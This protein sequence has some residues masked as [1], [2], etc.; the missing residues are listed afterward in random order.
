MI[1]WQGFFVHKDLFVDR[2]KQLDVIENCANS[3]RKIE[4]FK[5]YIVEFNQNR[6]IKPKMY[7]SDF[8][9]ERQDCQPVIVITYNK[10]IFSVNDKV[11]K[12]WI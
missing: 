8:I 10:F 7:L 12:A 4:K 6:A 9:V 1:S 2:D 11:L 5:S 3:L